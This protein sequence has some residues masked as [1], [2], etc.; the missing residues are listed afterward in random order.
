MNTILEVQSLYFRYAKAGPMILDS[1]N[2]EVEKGSITAVAGLSGCGKTTLAFC[3]CGAIPKSLPGIMEGDILLEGRSIRE[4]SLPSLSRKIGIVFQD[5]DNQIFLPTVEAEIAFAAE[6]LCLSYEEIEE[7]IERVLKTLG[8]E[9]LRS[10]NPSLLSGGE[11]HLAAMA[12]ILS[13]DP[14]II[15]LDEALS[16]LDR[17]S[18]DLIIDR[19]KLLQR[20]GKTIIAIDHDLENLMM[21][22]NILLMKDGRIEQRIKAGENRELLYSKLTDFFL[23]QSK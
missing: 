18:R 14:E 11:K 2:M 16:Q 9:H 23:Y 6:N 10:K 8:I 17:D 20:E 19:I 13:L 4:L 5:V 1:I 21:A 12:S 3:L 7:T 22:D 15:I